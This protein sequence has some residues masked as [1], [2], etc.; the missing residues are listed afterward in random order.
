MYLATFA[1]LERIFG[2][3]QSILAFIYFLLTIIN[4]HGAAIHGSCCTCCH[5]CCNNCRN[6][7]SLFGHVYHRGRSC[8]GYRS[9]GSEEYVRRVQSIL[10]I[11]EIIL[12]L[13]YSSFFLTAIRWWCL[14]SDKNI[15]LISAE[16]SGDKRKDKSP[17]FLLTFCNFCAFFELSVKPSKYFSGKGL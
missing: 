6:N 13:C 8:G 3:L 17:H 2:F 16:R 15:T 1:L 7:T 5:N 12:G 9:C 14:R 10:C 11:I 4:M